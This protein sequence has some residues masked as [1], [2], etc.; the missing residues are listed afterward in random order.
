[1]NTTI[2]WQTMFWLWL[3]GVGLAG[4]SSYYLLTGLHRVIYWE[5]TKGTITGVV[6]EE[7]DDEWTYYEKAEFV[8]PSGKIVEVIAFTGVG[9]RED[10][11][12]GEVTILYDPKQPSHATIFQLRD[13]LIVL[14][15]PFAALLMFLG[16]P[17]SKTPD[18]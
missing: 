10:T 7:S 8:D 16:W 9:A 11:H 17:F 6:E 2:N 4:L 13:Y 15:L 3:P 5:T 12:T 14:F 1:M 18:G